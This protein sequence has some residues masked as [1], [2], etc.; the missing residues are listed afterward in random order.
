MLDETLHRQESL[1]DGPH[2]TSRNGGETSERFLVLRRD[3]SREG[4]VGGR[5]R[6]AGHSLLESIRATSSIGPAE[7]LRSRLPVNRPSPFLFGRS[8]FPVL[9][10]IGRASCRERVYVVG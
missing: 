4:L 3:Q 5:R 9:A 2:K 7:A 6:M 8:K 10:K 1:T